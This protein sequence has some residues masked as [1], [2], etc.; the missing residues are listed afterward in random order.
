MDGLFGAFTETSGA[1]KIAVVCFI[2]A[3]F[4]FLLT[5]PGLIV[6]SKAVAFTGLVLYASLIATVIVICIY[7]MQ[8]ESVNGKQQ[9]AHRRNCSKRS[10]L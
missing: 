9:R 6:Q 2:K 10:C 1:M 3:K 4:M 5:T 7:E 8:K